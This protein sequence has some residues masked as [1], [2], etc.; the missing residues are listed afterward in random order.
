LA[1]NKTE[2]ITQILAAQPLLFSL[3]Q[4]SKDTLLT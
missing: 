3:G 4:P 2:K 1:K